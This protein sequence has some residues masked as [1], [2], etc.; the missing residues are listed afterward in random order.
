MTK[1]RRRRKKNWPEK[2]VYLGFHAVLVG[3]RT[4]FKIF[5]SMQMKWNFSQK[6]QIYTKTKK[7][8]KRQKQKHR[9]KRH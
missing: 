9:K 2:Y 6:P 5:H 4:C 1:A 8:I 7:S 3:C